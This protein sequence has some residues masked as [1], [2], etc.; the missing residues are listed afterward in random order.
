M[1]VKPRD[2]LILKHFQSLKKGSATQS[3]LR[4]KI[5]EQSL[6]LI[7]ELFKENIPRFSTIYRSKVIDAFIQ[8]SFRDESY[9]TNDILKLIGFPDFWLHLKRFHDGLYS[10]STSFNELVEYLEMNLSSTKKG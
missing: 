6:E 1:V 5:G 9:P 8:Y 2:K 7:R 10:R 4:R 3:R